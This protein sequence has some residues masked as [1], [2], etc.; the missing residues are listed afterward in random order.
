MSPMRSSLL[1]SAFIGCLLV[2][3]SAHAEDRQGT[4]I[5]NHNA[6]RSYVQDPGSRNSNMNMYRLQ[7]TMQQRER[8][9]NQTSNIFRSMNKTKKKMMQNCPDC[10]R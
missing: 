8:S 2:M 7:N 3:P 5:R 9:I 1:A 4:I 10:L 6:T